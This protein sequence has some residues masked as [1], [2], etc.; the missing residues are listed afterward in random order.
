MAID[1][2]ALDSI[3]LSADE[4]ELIVSRL[5]RAPEWFRVRSRLTSRF[6]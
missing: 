2:R 4:Y 3:A 6:W 5:G 1:Q